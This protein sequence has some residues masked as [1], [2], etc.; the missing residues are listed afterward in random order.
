MG[1]NLSISNS[2]MKLPFTFEYRDYR[3]FFFKLIVLMS[4][5]FFLD[6]GIGKVLHH[7][8]FS[9][10]SGMQYRTT[11]SIDKTRAIANI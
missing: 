6:Y 5:L 11:Y 10:K 2:D 3:Y 7:F 4:V 9:Q 1:G 8:Y